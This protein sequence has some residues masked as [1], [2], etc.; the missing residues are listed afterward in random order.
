MP[1]PIR[2]EPKSKRV[3]GSVTE[4][5]AKTLAVSRLPLSSTPEGT[6]AGGRLDIT[7]KT[8]ELSPYPIFGRKMNVSSPKLKS[9]KEGVLIPVESEI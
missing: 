8:F 5:G 7:P 3:V 1:T 4:P 6:I 2:P 9:A